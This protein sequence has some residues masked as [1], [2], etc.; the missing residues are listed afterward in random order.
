MKSNYVI[1]KIKNKKFKVHNFKP[2]CD[3]KIN[4]YYFEGQT[5]S[6]FLI[7]NK[8]DIAINT[9]PYEIKNNM[10]YPRGLYIY[11]KK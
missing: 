8:V 3:K 11:D 4:N 9:S 6:Q 5:T 2:I 1:A 10:Y 7:S